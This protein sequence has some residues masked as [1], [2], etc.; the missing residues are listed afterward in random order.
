[1]I[2]RNEIWVAGYPGF[3]GGSETEL[4]N[5]ILLWRMKGVQVNLVP[6]FSPDPSMV[7]RCTELGCLT[8]IYDHRIFKGRL[9]VSFCCKEFLD[10]LPFII[11]EG[12]PEAV[13][14]FNCM[15]W[16]FSGE[17]IAHQNKW[18]DYFGFVSE[19]QKSLLYPELEKINPVRDLK[20]YAPYFHL[21]SEMFRCADIRDK[22]TVGR[23][24]RDDASKYPFDLWRIF[25][26]I[27]SPV[28]VKSVIMG[29][30]NNAIRKCGFPP[31]GTDWEG[32]A[33][34]QMP[35]REF[36][37]K[38][39][40]VIHKTGGSRESYCRIVPEAYAYGVSLIVEN[41]F[42][43]PQLVENTITGFLCN[44]SDEM[45]F[46]ASQLAFDGSLRKKMILNG[47]Q[48]LRENIANVE[49]CWEPWKFLLN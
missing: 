38:V 44:S 9:V 6:L 5:N 3:L 7:K 36:Y 34:N 32:I 20:S 29:W 16:L 18:I 27:S 49:K 17:I 47:Y 21:E 2:F 23:C 35:V 41:N 15:T 42:A 40:C 13:I 43:F 14:W 4:Y 24:S 46:R 45:S 30:G 33:P 31:M 12:K 39:D 22:F 10:L 19:Y 8:H 28:P 25:Y 1:M 48:F 26:K 11:N 37:R